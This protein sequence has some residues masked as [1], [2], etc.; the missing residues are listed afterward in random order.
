MSEP[1]PKSRLLIVD[2]DPLITDTLAYALGKD[3]EVLVSDSR[4]HAVSLL[5]QLDHL[6]GRLFSTRPVA[7]GLSQLTS[8]KSLQSSHRRRRVTLVQPC[9][10]GLEPGLGF[11]QATHP[12]IGSACDQLPAG[13]YGLLV[14]IHRRDVMAPG[15]VGMQ[16]EQR[17]QVAQRRGS[18]RLVSLGD[19]AHEFGHALHDNARK[20]L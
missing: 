19:E 5:R 17:L 4:A 10:H 8:D 14:G 12:A 3:F 16:L 6:R 15:E 13:L 2:D 9:P 11:H 7:L 1:T 18:A 20:H